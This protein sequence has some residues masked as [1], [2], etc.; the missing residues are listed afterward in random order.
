MPRVD[1]LQEKRIMEKT[2][3]YIYSIHPSSAK[4]YQDFREVNGWK[5]MK[6]GIVEFVTKFPK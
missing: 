3:C 1:G 5:G 2:N 4:M 6:K